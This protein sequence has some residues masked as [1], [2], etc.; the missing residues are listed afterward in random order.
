MPTNVESLLCPRLESAKMFYSG[1][2]YKWTTFANNHQHL[3]KLHLKYFDFNQVTSITA[4]LMELT[5]VK[6]TMPRLNSVE[7]IR[8]ILQSYPNLVKAHFLTDF[9]G[10]NDA[11]LRDVR[12]SVDDEWDFEE[13]K[14][15]SNFIFT[16]ID[17]DILE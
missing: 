11:D 13:I 7:G 3:K 5:E 1:F 8:N 16:R 17:S 9:E 10:I 2:L 14:P 12:D 6:L 15:N 4:N